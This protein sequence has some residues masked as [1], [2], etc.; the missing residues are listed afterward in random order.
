MA[1]H[2]A[3]PPRVAIIEREGPAAAT[4]DAHGKPAHV[5]VEGLVVAPD[6]GHCLAKHLFGQ[7][8]ALGPVF[9]PSCIRH[10][11]W[12]RLPIKLSMPIWVAGR[13]RMAER[14]P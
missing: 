5:G 3:L 8:Y 2:A 11:A 12:F 1:A 14:T 4:V 6:N 7:L 9:P 13:Q 10:E